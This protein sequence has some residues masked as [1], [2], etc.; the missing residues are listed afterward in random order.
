MKRWLLAAC[1]AGC[2]SAVCAFDLEEAWEAAER[3]SAEYR[4]AVYHRDAE[5]E[6]ERQA[7]AV[8]YPHVSADGDYRRQ[9]SD[10]SSAR[11]QYGWQI[12]VS[13]SLYDAEKSVRLKQS[14]SNSEEADAGL[15]RQL[16]ELKLQ[17]GRSY[18]DVLLAEENV[19][20]ARTEKDTYRKQI[21]QTQKL[22]RHG[23]ATAVD[24]HEAQVGYDQALAKEIEALGQKQSAQNRLSNYTGLAAADIQVIDSEGL[25]ERFQTQIDQHDLNAW[26]QAALE[27]NSEYR[28]QRAA[29]ETALYGVDL[30]KAAN[31]PKVNL[32]AGYQN[33]RY[34]PHRGDAYGGKGWTFGIQI[35]MPLYSG[36]GDRS[37]IRE[38]NARL[39]EAQERLSATKRKIKLAVAQAYTESNAAR[40]RILAQQRVLDSSRLKLKATE[41]GRQYGI[42]NTL[43][44]VRARQEVAEAEQ[45]L[46][47]ARYAYLGAFLS[48]VKESGMDMATAWRAAHTG[49]NA[50]TD[51]AKVRSVPYRSKPKRRYWLHQ[52]R[53]LAV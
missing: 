33:R 2:A 9:P 22:F 40:Y 38:A 42:R 1:L 34:H 48:L 25:I 24:L 3:H 29:V 35:S 20:A 51:A 37:R 47:Q 44:T 5:R 49:K 32:T 53:M 39:D 8:W 28:S 4:A 36:G 46:A 19:Q 21:N 43:E 50:S 12:Q 18:F 30:A 27:H 14:R 31:R 10:L 15:A 7:E 11:S 26:Q 41:T 16:D 13:Q 6:K 52:A 23:L 45:K 17:V